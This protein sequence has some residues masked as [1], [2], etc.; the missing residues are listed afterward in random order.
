MKKYTIP[1]VIDYMEK[2]LLDNIDI[3]R[4]QMIAFIHV[5]FSSHNDTT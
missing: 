2:I 4:K 5:G 3:V 1:V